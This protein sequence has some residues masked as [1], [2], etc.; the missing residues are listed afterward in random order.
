VILGRIAL[1]MSVQSFITISCQL[2]KPQAKE[3]E[4]LSSSKKTDVIMPVQL[5]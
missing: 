4:Q 2:T 3:Q 5:G 1:Q